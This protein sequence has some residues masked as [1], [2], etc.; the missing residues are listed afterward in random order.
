MG[1]GAHGSQKPATPGATG[2]GEEEPH[3]KKGPLNSATLGRGL[4]APE[5]HRPHLQ[6]NPPNPPPSADERPDTHMSA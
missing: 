3:S 2:Q 1:G 5:F 4:L 6:P